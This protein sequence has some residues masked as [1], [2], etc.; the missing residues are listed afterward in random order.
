MIKSF[1]TTSCCS[2]KFPPNKIEK[3][4]WLDMRGSIRYVYT[5]AGD[6]LAGKYCVSKLWQGTSEAQKP[7]WRGCACSL[8]A[9]MKQNVLWT[10]GVLKQ[11]STLDI[12]SP[13]TFQCLKLPFEPFT[14]LWIHPC[15]SQPRIGRPK[16]RLETATVVWLYVGGVGLI[17]LTCDL[18]WFP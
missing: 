3:F 5:E 15:Y 17:C 14:S 9:E 13:D 18:E 10:F 11:A 12:A 7:A 2:Q 6:W 8:M 1:P 4:G 16:F